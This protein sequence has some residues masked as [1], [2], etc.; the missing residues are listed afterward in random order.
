VQSGRRLIRISWLNLQDITV[1]F[2]IN[3]STL[4]ME[5]ARSS[6]ESVNLYQITRS[7]RKFLSIRVA[8]IVGSADI[9]SNKPSI[10]KNI[11]EMFDQL[12]YY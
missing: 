8:T 7:H 2:N 5:A 1:Y 12:R 6:R 10:T 9:I 4:K 11:K 3:S